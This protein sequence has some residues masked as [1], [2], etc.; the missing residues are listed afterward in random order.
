MFKANNV[1][2]VKRSVD[3]N[4]AHQLLFG[5]AFGKRGLSNDFRGTHSFVVKICEFITFSETS[6]AQESTSLVLFDIYIT[7]ILD[8]FFLNYDI[9]LINRLF[10]SRI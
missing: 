5:S 7:V 9:L 10:R 6:F 1:C 4:F 2:V 8:N 3:F